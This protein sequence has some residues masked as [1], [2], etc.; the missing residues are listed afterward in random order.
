MPKELCSCCHST[1]VQILAAGFG[2]PA[3]HCSGAAGWIRG[4]QVEPAPV[5]AHRPLGR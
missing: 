1:E 4:I 3:L 2:V 5:E